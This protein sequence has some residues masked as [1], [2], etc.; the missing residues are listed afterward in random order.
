MDSSSDFANGSVTVWLEFNESD[1]VLR[2][3]EEGEKRKEIRRL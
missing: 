3:L 2:F 1:A